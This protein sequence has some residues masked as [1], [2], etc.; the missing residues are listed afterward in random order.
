LRAELASVFLAAERGIPYDPEQHAAYVGSWIKTLKE[1][2]NEIFRAAHDASRATDF[3]L[4][5]ERDRSIAGEAL[6]DGPGLHSTKLRALPNVVLERETEKRERDRKNWGV[7]PAPS[8][9]SAGRA[10]NRETLGHVRTTGLG[11]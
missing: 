9:G 6:P 5:L 11:R 7:G 10:A 2:K 1:D 4:A 8:E 3:L